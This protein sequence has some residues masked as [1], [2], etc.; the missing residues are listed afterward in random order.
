MKAVWMFF[1]VVVLLVG[2]TSSCHSCANCDTPWWACDNTVWD[3]ESE[4]GEWFCIGPG[5]CKEYKELR[6]KCVGGMW[7][8]HCLPDNWDDGCLDDEE[9]EDKC[10]DEA[11]KYGTE[12]PIYTC[13]F[14]HTCQLT[15]MVCA[16]VAKCDQ[17]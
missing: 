8:Y 12:Y 1:I 14:L 6:I 3:W 4:D 10:A 13:S 9:Q 17:P 2:C 15:K 7:F 11:F 5:G 16:N